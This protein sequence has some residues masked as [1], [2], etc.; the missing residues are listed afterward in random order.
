MK[1]RDCLA[2]LR[3]DG[4]RLAGLSKATV[5]ALEC[6]IVERGRST[7]ATRNDVID[8][9]R[10]PVTELREVTV[11]APAGVTAEYDVAQCSRDR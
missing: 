10:R 5:R 7:A 11:L 4:G 3:I 2:V 8:V 1:Q 9:E 6:Q